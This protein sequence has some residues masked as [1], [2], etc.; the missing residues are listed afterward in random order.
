MANHL[1]KKFQSVLLDNEQKSRIFFHLTCILVSCETTLIHSIRFCEEM[2]ML[3]ISNHMYLLLE[4]IKAMLTIS[5]VRKL[6][7]N[8]T[9]YQKIFSMDFHFKKCNKLY[10]SKYVKRNV[11]LCDRPFPIYLLFQR[12]YIL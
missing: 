11:T 5:F 10:I 7:A 6:N 9:A 8:E 2:L 1:V 3:N 4:T 12:L